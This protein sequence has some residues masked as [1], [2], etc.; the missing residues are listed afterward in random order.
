MTLRLLPS[1]LTIDALDRDGLI[2]FDDGADPWADAEIVAELDRRSDALRDAHAE[3]ADGVDHHWMMDPHHGPAAVGH[4]I[5]GRIAWVPMLTTAG[6][7]G[8]VL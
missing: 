3:D 2:S 1:A 8:R 4:V 5:D 6:R 7:I